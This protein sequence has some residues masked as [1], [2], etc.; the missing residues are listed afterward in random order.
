[1]FIRTRMKFIDNEYVIFKRKEYYNQELQQINPFP[2]WIM[3][4]Q[5]PCDMPIT[6]YDYINDIWKIYKIHL[7]KN[8]NVIWNWCKI[9][10]KGRQLDG[11]YI[12]V[13]DTDNNCEISVI[14]S[15]KNGVLIDEIK[16]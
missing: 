4:V 2:E 7:L 10:Y 16:D 13:I 9:N 8:W 15:L 6:I 14:D 12:R 5:N 3:N 1:M 11:Y